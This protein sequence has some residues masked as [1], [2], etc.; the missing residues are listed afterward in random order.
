M[1]AKSTNVTSKQMLPLFQ[2][3]SD[4]EKPGGSTTSLQTNNN[5]SFYFENTSVL[6]SDDVVVHKYSQPDIN[7]TELFLNLDGNAS[8]GGIEPLDQ[9]AHLVDGIYSKKSTVKRRYKKR[10]RKMDHKLEDGDFQFKGKK[11][12]EKHRHHRHKKS[13]NIIIYIF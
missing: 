11:V 7:S 13:V 8:N 2:V 9:R 12:S 4:L 6:R 10:R 5:S 1:G 3:I